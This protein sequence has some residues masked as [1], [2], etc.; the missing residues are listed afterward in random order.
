M[1][2]P[3][4]CAAVCCLLSSA[5]SSLP[6]LTRNMTTA[7]PSVKSRLDIEIVSDTVCPWCYVGKRRLERALTSV[8]RS[9][10]DVNVTWKP[11]QL[12]P[13]A[14]PVSKD[15][16]QAYRDKFGDERVK[17]MLPYMQQVGA[18]E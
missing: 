6:S 12:N 4:V 13:T 14:G 17:Q 9:R 8:D 18:A 2:T 15:K 3:S 11:Y 7:S 10:V 1:S 16:L 5:S